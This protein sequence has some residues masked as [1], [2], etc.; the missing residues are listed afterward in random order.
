MYCSKCGKQIDYESTV[1]A[2]CVAKMANKAG[3][4]APSADVA[5][6]VAAAP[7]VTH[8]IAASAPQA[9]TRMLGFGKALASTILS[10]ASIFLVI[11]SLVSIAT[12]LFGLGIFLLLASIA[13]IVISIIFGIKSIKTFIVAK[14]AGTGTPVATLVLGINGLVTAAFSAL[15]VI[16]FGFAVVVATIALLGSGV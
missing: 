14:K 10:F 8:V 2:E 15:Y 6:V 3:E 11:F 7:E 4:S 12:F 13:A 5:P 1:C 9:N 16:I